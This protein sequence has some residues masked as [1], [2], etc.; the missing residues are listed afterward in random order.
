[1]GSDH[2]K[3]YYVIIASE[4]KDDHLQLRRVIN[5][6][7]P[8]AIVESIYQDEEFRC[9]EKKMAFAPDLFFFDTC[10]YSKVS[11]ANLFESVPF[12]VIGDEPEEVVESEYFQVH[13][14]YFKRSF[15]SNA[16][17]WLARN[18]LRKFNS[19]QEDFSLVPCNK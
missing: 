10:F 17:Q 12:I 1:M 19:L 6:M 8:Q 2:K 5:K 9:F 18:L 13:C 7:L 16:V 14:R 11:A 15:D 3:I 4:R